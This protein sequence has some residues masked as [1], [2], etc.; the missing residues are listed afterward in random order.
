MRFNVNVSVE[1][2]D[3]SRF[4]CDLLSSR[5]VPDTE[6]IEHL[7]KTREYKPVM[8]EI[9]RHRKKLFNLDSTLEDVSKIIQSYIE[10]KNPPSPPTEQ[11]GI[12]QEDQE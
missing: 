11:V 7:L 12:K 9:E 5:R 4:I 2:E 3:L 8:D 6:K 10:L 1:E